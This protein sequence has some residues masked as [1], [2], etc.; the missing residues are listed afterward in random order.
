MI[1]IINAY[2]ILVGKFITKKPLERFWF[3][4]EDNIKI[5]LKGTGVEDVN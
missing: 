5:C 3:R 4:W 2:K 1:H